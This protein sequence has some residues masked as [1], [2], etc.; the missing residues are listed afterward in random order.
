[1]LCCKIT[2][3]QLDNPYSIPVKTYLYESWATSGMASG[4]MCASAAEK[5][6]I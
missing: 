3:S 6:S 5:S 2:D 4:Q 1:L